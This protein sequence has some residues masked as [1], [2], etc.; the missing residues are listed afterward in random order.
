[1]AGDVGRRRSAKRPEKA[2]AMADDQIGRHQPAKD[3]RPENDDDGN[4]RLVEIVV[5]A[6]FPAVLLVRTQTD[7]CNRQTYPTMPRGQGQS[8]VKNRDGV[9]VRISGN[10]L[11]WRGGILSEGAEHA[12]P[13]CGALPLRLGPRYKGPAFAGQPGK[14]DQASFSFRKA[15]VR[16]HARSAASLLYRAS[17]ASLLKARLTPS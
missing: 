1:M 5:H 6:S 16:L 8:A 9:E 7:S 11:I 4:A 15:S 14:P 10:G 13:C 12:P 2:V 3:K 17:D